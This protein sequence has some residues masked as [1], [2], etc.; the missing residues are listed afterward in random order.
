VSDFDDEPFKENEMLQHAIKVVMINK[1]ID[2]GIAIVEGEAEGETLAVFRRMLDKYVYEFAE[3]MIKDRHNLAAGVGIV[4]DYASSPE[5][6][7]QM[8]LS[9]DKLVMK[10]AS[11]MITTYS[12]PGSA[13]RI[14]EEGASA[15]AR[16]DAMLLRLGLK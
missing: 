6:A 14:I 13:R 16:R 4:E 9:L 5:I 2:L 1:N 11:N 8:R 3:G 7:F 15:P 12:S 10:E